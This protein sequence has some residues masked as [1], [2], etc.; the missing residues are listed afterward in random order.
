MPGKKEQEQEQEQFSVQCV[1]LDACV[2]STSLFLFSLLLISPSFH[3][4]KYTFVH[5]RS[6]ETRT[7]S[8]RRRANI[9]NPPFSFHVHSLVTTKEVTV[10][11]HFRYLFLSRE[12]RVPALNCFDKE[13]TV[14]SATIFKLT[15][16]RANISNLYTTLTTTI[17]LFVLHDRF[18][19]K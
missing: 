10:Q 16:L 3:S 4:Y 17:A 2:L 8:H 11:R 6:R 14:E 13:G 12:Q 1:S 7:F 9:L 5:S 19:S 15:P 18:E